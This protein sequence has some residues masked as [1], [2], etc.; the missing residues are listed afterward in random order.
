GRL[1]WLL[2]GLLPFLGLPTEAAVGLL[3][4]LLALRTTMISMAAPAWTALMAQAVP[5]RLR[6]RYFANRNMLSS[7]A[8]LIGSALGGWLVR[9]GGYPA[10]YTALFG[11]AALAGLFS[12]INASRLPQ[13]PLPASPPTAGSGTAEMGRELD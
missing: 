4:G 12:F 9:L 13:I 11:L 8:A 1:L 10:G 2:P 3:I 6:G 7:L 5:M